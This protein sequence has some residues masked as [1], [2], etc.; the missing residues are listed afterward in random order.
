MDSGTYTAP[1]KVTLAGY[2][3]EWLKTYPV[4]AK[5]APTTLAGYRTIGHTIK[6]SLGFLSLSRLTPESIDRFYVEKINAGLS[7]TTVH[8]Y[9]RLLREILGHAVRKGKLAR[10]PALLADVPTKDPYR[11]VV[12]DQEQVRLFLGKAKRE[13]PH[14][15]L[16][17][18]AILTGMRQ[19]ELLGLRWSDVDLEIGECH[20][21]QTFY[22]LAG[23]KRDGRA[24]EQL[25]KAPKT[26]GSRRTLPST[27][28]ECLR[29]LR[30]T[31]A[32]QRQMLGDDY[33]DHG[34]VFCQADGK[35]L[36]AG[37]I[38]KRDFHPLVKEAG[39]PRVR[40]HSL[41]HAHVAYLALA[42]VSIKV[43][44]ERLGHASAKMTLDVY[45]HVLPGMQEDAARKVEAL[46]LGVGR[47]GEEQAPRVAE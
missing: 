17:L 7:R 42:G 6:A 11:A 28:V 47:T 25:F 9:H 32:E 5:L 30:E 45:S 15:P 24:A 4:T 34:L 21:R 31:Q 1:T 3:D 36:H 10:N 2:V 18:A 29:E 40:F 14:H 26:E 20:V 46:L 16:Y 43:A 23:S 22:R 44:Q 12:W 35:P 39:L 41:R 27:V 19:G 13:S 8:A 37:N 38:V 33:H